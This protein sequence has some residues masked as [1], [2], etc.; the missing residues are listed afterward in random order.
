MKQPKFKIVPWCRDL[1]WMFA[2]INILVG[3]GMALFYET[4]IP[5]AVANLLSYREWGIIF[6]GLGVVGAIAL[7]L[8]KTQLVKN[9]QLVSVAVKMVWLL[10]LIIRG[11]SYPQTILI[12]LV[13]AAF[14]L[15]QIEVYVRF[16]TLPE[17]MS[18]GVQ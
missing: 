11:V 9:T 8:G 13:W 12:T 7:V 16:Q 4:P 6:I 3:I 15:V 14:A 1:C 2:V 10:A 18:H 17:S 5:L